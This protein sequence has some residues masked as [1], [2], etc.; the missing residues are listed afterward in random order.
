MFGQGLSLDQAP[1]F[2]APFRFFIT[3]P[4]FGMMA[5]LI[6]L[7][8][9]SGLFGDTRMLSFVGVTHLMTLGIVTMVM[10][11]AMQQMLPVIAGVRFEAPLRNARLI[12]MGMGAGT[13]LFAVGLLWIS[14]PLL[15][16]GVMIVMATILFFAGVV[17]MGLL[18]VENRSDSVRAFGYAV[19]SLVVAVGFGAAVGF[20]FGGI[21]DH[22]GAAPLHINWIVFGW[23]MLLVIGVSFQVVPMFY[24]TDPYPSFCRKRGVSVIF[25]MLVLI[26]AVSVLEIDS[27]WIVPGAHL[28]IVV[29][30]AGYAAVTVRMLYRRKRAVRDANV[31]FWY[32][33]MGSLFLGVIGWY[34]GNNIAG[35]EMLRTGA[36]VL[37]GT[38]FVL[39]L[40]S[41]ML[42][43]IVPFLVWFHLTNMGHFGVPTM[44]ELIGEKRIKAHLYLHIA[45]VFGFTGGAVLT[46]SLY[47]AAGLFF[48]LANGLLFVN[49]YG[50]GRVYF[51]KSKETLPSMAFDME[52]LSKKD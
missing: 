11:G 12:H 24:V 36:S 20:S 35:S 14:T 34:I 40:L 52:S 2:S 46:P 4:L 5:G 9:D 51:R 30:T 45:A 18:R 48:F 32:F 10:M 23:I 19:I 33:A 15:L 44:R 42:Y 16:A 31:L 26:S 49:L 39:S 13:L 8:G 17:G 1:P 47:T 43:K 22:T 25:G 7:V 38:G 3:A 27:A 50:A 37:F 21:G 41:A 6:L 28:V 29:L